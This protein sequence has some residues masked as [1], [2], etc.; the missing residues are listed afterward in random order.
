MLLSWLVGLALAAPDSWRDVRLLGEPGRP[1]FRQADRVYDP[2]GGV[3]FALEPGSVLLE[4]QIRFAALTDDT[5]VVRTA[6]GGEWARVHAG[7]LGAPIAGHAD[8]NS[9]ALTDGRTV[10]R[11]EG[12]AIHRWVVEGQYARRV[13]LNAD[14]GV[15]AQLDPSGTWLRYVPGRIDPISR[16]LDDP[17]IPGVV[18]IDGDAVAVALTLATG[19]GINVRHVPMVCCT[20]VSTPL[21]GEGTWV[22]DPTTGQDLG[23]FLPQTRRAAVTE[24]GAIAV[25]GF[26]DRLEGWSSARG[27][28]RWSQPYMNPQPS[29]SAG[30]VRVDQADRIDLLEPATGVVRWVVRREGMHSDRGLSVEGPEGR[31]SPDRSDPGAV[32]RLSAWSVVTDEPPTPQP[33][34][35][36][37]RHG[38]AEG[39]NDE[40]DRWSRLDY[41]R[42]E[43]LFRAVYGAVGSGDW[44]YEKIAL[45]CPPALPALGDGEV[46]L[47]LRGVRIAGLELMAPEWTLD[48]PHENFL[49]AESIH[50]GLV[51]AAYT[52]LFGVG[53][54][55]E[56][57]WV[58]E[59]P[60]RYPSLALHHIPGGV[61]V[62]LDDEV[63]VINY[64]G[65]VRW[66]SARYQA[67]ARW[68]G[69]DATPLVLSDQE[70][71][72]RR[73]DVPSRWREVDP[74]T[75]E[76]GRILPGRPLP[77]T[78]PESERVG[79]LTLTLEDEELIAAGPKGRAVWHIRGVGEYQVLSDRRVLVRAVNAFCGDAPPRSSACTWADVYSWA[80][81][82]ARRG[83]ILQVVA[84]R[85]VFHV[86][87]RLFGLIDGALVGWNVR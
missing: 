61:L 54:E 16:Q 53:V 56:I 87:D 66:W 49:Q 50:D 37:D 6:D 17:D 28:R 36:L 67:A 26:A 79:R 15:D 25:L 3:A 19:R 7:T 45:W 86:G 43:A 40:S 83:D 41:C 84:A 39:A 48:S 51:V 71:P 11:L 20:P 30:V 76:P 85:R 44:V 33:E 1:L 35:P 74:R 70:R 31:W 22:W 14:G 42:D 5:I 68:T 23:E 65:G 47:D 62:A 29:I 9:V 2:V 63:L 80:V 57:R 59:L 46:P 13:R 10:A 32:S 81:V 69:P 55:G 75:G 77:V 82:D 52:R 4:G 8:L 21:R 27:E 72:S 73:G 60:P 78:P 12:G 24:D 58:R 64:D 38:I 18:M 34:R